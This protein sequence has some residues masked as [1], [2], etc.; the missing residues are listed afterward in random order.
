MPKI[1]QLSLHE[2]QKIA[3]GEVVERPANVVKELVENALD[4]GATSITIKVSQGGKAAI[5]VIDNGCGMDEEDAKLCFAQHAT[6]K[7]RSI[8][9]LQY[10]QTFG[11]RGEALAS[12]AAVSKITLI[13]KEAHAA[14]GTKICVEQGS[15][16]HQSQVAC[17]QGTDIL[18]KDL[19][20]NVPARKKF[21]KTTETEWRAI[22]HLFTALCLSYQE[23]HFKLEHDGSLI[24]N[25]PPTTTLSARLTQLWE[26][27]SAAHFLSLHTI[28]EKNVQIT[29][30]ISNVQYT[31]YDRSNIYLFVNKR[32]IKNQKV[33]SAFIK[34]YLN[35]LPPGKFP[36]GCIFI[37]LKNEE[38]DI[39]IHP[40][41]EE[42][43][44]LHPRVIENLVQDSVKKTFEQKLSASLK[45]A[46]KQ[47]EQEDNAVSSLSSTIRTDGSTRPTAFT[48][49]SGRGPLKTAVETENM[50]SNL[51]HDLYKTFSMYRGEGV[52][53]ETRDESNN[54]SL[55]NLKPQL[56]L[57]P[58][59]PTPQQTQQKIITPQPTAHNEP[60]AFTILGQ[61]E[62]TYILLQTEQG[63]LLVDQHAAHERILFELFAQRFDQVATI[64]LLFPQIIEL[65]ERDFLHIQPH[66]PLLHSYGINAETF[67]T[68]Q[69]IIQSAP[70]HLKDA[71][72]H[73]FIQ[74]TLSWIYEYETMT[75]AEFAHKIQYNIQAH[76]ACKAAVKAG[77]VLSHEKI[78]KLL[79][80]L[81][82]TDNRFTCPHG[83]P[84]SWLISLSEI[85]K[86]FKRDYR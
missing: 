62:N 25:C 85:E 51:H 53:S 37:T 3:A 48:P 80:D 75:H 79:A 13:T 45:A 78:E 32:W 22:V 52:S 31:R 12:I 39:N 44:F 84:T 1:H 26:H 20:F 59:Q 35:M 14:T 16:T 70:V 19:F 71:S 21:L 66:L 17:T 9:D 18:I 7:V 41:K 15:F 55:N 11:F 34:G 42:V 63:L 50:Q 67:G 58:T 43:Q 81:Y 82:T 2:A 10:L 28:D 73:E 69:L 47:F 5:N 61:L 68:N 77:D 65:N 86:K 23:I 56:T 72:M 33:T 57:H 8:N 24:Y 76:M 30:M 74:K 4:A 29:G 54:Q 38:V 49:A 40:R 46:T 83:R 64:Q 6:S 36:A 60:P 27:N